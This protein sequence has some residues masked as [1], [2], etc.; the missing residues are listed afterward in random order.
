MVYN[1]QNLSNV[2][3]SKKHWEHNVSETGSV[4]VFR[5]GGGETA[6][7]LGPLKRPNQRLEL[8]LSEEPNRLGV[9]HNLT[10]R[11]KHIQFP[12]LCVL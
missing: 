10:W 1:I 11:R 9:S 8:A 6:T 4:S 2:R 7:M 5:W 3:Y 12:K